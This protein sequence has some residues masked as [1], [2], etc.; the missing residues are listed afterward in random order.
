MIR[1]MGDRNQHNRRLHLAVATTLTLAVAA[2]AVGVFTFLVRADQEA[3]T[4]VLQSQADQYAGVISSRFQRHETRVRSA[5]AFF[6]ASSNVTRNDWADFV[7]ETEAIRDGM[8]EMF[9]AEEINRADLQE[10]FARMRA[11]G[12]PEIHPNPPDPR[13]RYCLILYTEPVS[14]H[15]ESLGLDICT[16][17]RTEPAAQRT[18]ET[19]EVSMSMS[20][21]IGSDGEESVRGHVLLGW[22]E[23]G[24]FHDGGWVGG[25]VALDSHFAGLGIG[26]GGIILTVRDPLDPDNDPLFSSADRPSDQSLLMV[27][28]EIELG[29]RRFQLQFEQ[30][31]ATEPTATLLLLAGLTIAGL[32]GGLL[33]STLRTRSRAERMAEEATEAYRTSEELLTSVTDNI[34]EGIYRGVPEEGLVYIN[35]ALADMFGFSETDDMIAHSGPILYASPNV[36]E[37]LFRLLREQGSYRNEE[38]EFVRPDGSHFFAINSAVAT[39]NADGSVA[40]FDGVI[41]D[42]TD[43]KEAEAEVHRLAHYDSLTGLPNRTLLNDRLHQAV[44]HA[45]RKQR[46]VAV[47]F[48]D[49]DRFKAVNDSLGHGIGDRLLVAVSR[50][51]RDALREYDTISRLGGD[52]FVI[53]MPGAGFEAAAH[54]ADSLIEDFRNPFE[55]DGHELTITPSIG[56]SIFPDDGD[57]PETLLRNADTAMYHAKERGRATFEFFT[58]EL[59]QRAYERLT[60]ETHLRN[61]LAR[62][63][64]HLV[65]QPILD[66][67]TRQIQSVEAL[68]RWNSPVLGRVRPDQFIPVAE[69]SGLIIDIGQ[70][71]IEKSLQQLASWKRLGMTDLKVSVNVSAVQFWR[72]NLEQDVRRAL[73]ESELQ[74]S[75][76]EVELTENVIMSDADSA[77]EALGG[78][79]PMGVRI[80]IDDFGTGYS[81]LSYLKQFQIDRLKIDRSFVQDLSVDNDDAAIVSA[82]LSMA[83]DL[84]IQ[85]VAEGV[86]TADQLDYL[87]S[88]GCD[89]VQGYY[90]SKPLPP[91]ELLRLWARNS[92]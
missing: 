35:Q 50:R 92:R 18:R 57:Q 88:R 31:A 7:E 2:A 30:P 8:F 5:A 91:N 42:I 89:F 60:M 38:V 37:R 80:A 52:E 70:W 46:S 78:L 73:S 53:V 55:I 74:G 62:G 72:G 83:R 77:R 64:L 61:A 40:Y 12:F 82:V 29:G 58:S 71:V 43:R 86:E 68:L 3:R 33:F 22:V 63:E 59:N 79:K 51:L 44:A 15:A 14:V 56:I 4:V 47:I 27:E 11:D 66:T 26:Q 49:L 24:R 67:T 41:S 84:G 13:E 25:T 69:Q 16:R 19:G 32:L 21:N 28:R 1:A 76:L 45:S 87:A 90:F 39:L 48:M 34:S 20:V 54:R 85:V 65:Y 10:F 75:D 9:W 23:A 17:P 6:A 36:R 81:S